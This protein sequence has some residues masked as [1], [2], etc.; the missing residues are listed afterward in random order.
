MSMNT[1]PRS[2]GDAVPARLTPDV[3]NS[4]MRIT[5][6]RITITE[7]LVEQMSR[8]FKQYLELA[9]VVNTPNPEDTEEIKCAIVGFSVYSATENWD[10]G[11]YSFVNSRLTEAPEPYEREVRLLQAMCLGGLC[12]MAFERSITETEFQLADIQLPGYLLALGGK[13][14]CEPEAAG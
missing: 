6:M 2:A 13:V 8:N 12:G 11:H 9:L 10:R 7:G 4:I 3:R 5:I 1:E 14:R